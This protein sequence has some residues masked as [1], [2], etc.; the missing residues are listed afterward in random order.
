L[1]VVLLDI[2]GE[3]LDGAKA[4]LAGLLPAERVDTVQGN[5]FRLAQKPNL[6]ARLEK[7]N[8]ILCTGLFD[9]L[10][11][12]AAAQLLAEFWHRLAPGGA[13]CVFTFAPHNPTRAY[14]EWIGN[15]YLTYRDDSDLASLAAAAQIPPGCVTLGS[16]AL[17]V[18]RYLLAKKPAAATPTS[19]A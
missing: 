4:R 1:Q 14:M 19:P 7:S 17:G 11:D 12:A 3:A 2:D 9:Y 8:L 10:N 16:E 15:W 18:D 5:L 13:A 6:A